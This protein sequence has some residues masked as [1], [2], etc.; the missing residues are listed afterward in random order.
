[1]IDIMNN[2][3]EMV[4]PDAVFWGGGHKFLI[5]PSVYPFHDGG[6]RD[7]FM[8]KLYQGKIFG[9]DGAMSTLLNGVKSFGKG[10][11][12]ADTW[13]NIT[14]TFKKFLGEGLG[15]I[16]SVVS[17]VAGALF[18]ESTGN[19]LDNFVNKTVGEDNANAGKAKMNALFGN[20]ET[21]WRNKVIETTMM[22]QISGMASLLIGEPVGEWHLTVGNPLNPIMVV[23]NLIC[24]KM[25]VQLSDSLGPDDFPDEMSVT[26]SLQHGMA[27][28]KAGIQSM[29]NRGM[30]KS[31]ELPDYIKSS[32]QQETMVDHYT[33]GTSFR[34]PKFMNN[35]AE[36]SQGMKVNGYKGVSRFQNYKVDPGS[37]PA[38]SSP[39]TATALITKFTPVNVDSNSYADITGN[40]SFTSG[41][42]T[43]NIPVIRSLAITR[44][45][46][47]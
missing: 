29:F 21:L 43:N 45:Y 28:D 23:G 32:S 42:S 2:C 10:D 24:E 1:M 6:W 47:S 13:S 41:A 33:G 40:T 7:S 39:N 26:Y 12:G 44:T 30:G 25:E 19:F 16:G 5:K 46:S 35:M 4:S 27:R 34:E 3:L 37:V 14:D 20:L 18:G 36:L 15:A 8:K 31:Y 22:P 11:G 17:S 38:M 9:K